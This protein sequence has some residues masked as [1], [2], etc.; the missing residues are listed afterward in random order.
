MKICFVVEYYPPHLGGGENLFASLAEGLAERGH[1]CRVV[2]CGL[3]GVPLR[4]TRNGVK[5]LRVRVPKWGDRMW[6]T[7]LGLK[8]ALKAARNADIIHT[9]TYNGAFP[10][11]IAGRIWG[12]PVVITAHEVLGPLW[13]RLKLPPATAWAGHLA[14]KT[15]LSLPFDGYSCNSQSTQKGLTHYGIGRDRSFL[16]Y[17]AP[18]YEKF[19]PSP[20][21]QTDRAALRKKLGLPESAFIYL[22]YGRP[23]ILKGV[24]TLVD[25]APMVR[26]AVPESVLVMVLSRRPSGGYRRVVEKIS[27]LP[28]GGVILKDSVPGNELPDW[29]QA[30]DCVV[31]PSLSEG[32]GFCC[33]EACAM[34]KPV[35]ATRAGSLPEV[36]GGRHILVQP[37]STQALAEGIILASQGKWKQKARKAFSQNEFVENH[38]WAYERLLARNPAD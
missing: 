33:A 7:F 9:T 25:A 30:A 8:Q 10:A 6:F 34:G 27:R 22:Y 2:T 28:E 21:K 14:E 19:C 17:P 15:V 13:H 36:A 3:P 31:A 26:E 18:D 5:I 1:D 32:F 11:W 37:G 16:A 38:L 24:K 29:I 12:K 20:D 23:G 4:E 35:V